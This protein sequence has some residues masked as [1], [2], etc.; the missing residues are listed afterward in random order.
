MEYNGI[1]WNCQAVDDHFSKALSQSSD[2]GTISDYI[3]SSMPGILFY[4]SPYH[5]FYLIIKYSSKD[6]VNMYK[7]AFYSLR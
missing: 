2:E 1:L 7:A 5:I 3:I 6:A 4:S